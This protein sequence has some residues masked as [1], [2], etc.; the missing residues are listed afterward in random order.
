[1]SKKGNWV[2]TMICEIK[3]EVYCENC[4]ENEARSEPFKYAV[5]E[6]DIELTDWRVDCIERN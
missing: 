5:D 1:M 4:T 6:R 3:R 2:V